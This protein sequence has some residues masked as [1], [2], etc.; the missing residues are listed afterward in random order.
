MTKI[1]WAIVAI[2]AVL[3]LVLLVIGLT[4]RTHPDGGKEM[5]LIFGVIAPGLL[6]GLAVLAFTLSRSTFIRAAALAVAAAPLLLVG[7]SHLRNAW[8]DYQI[9]HHSP[10]T[11]PGRAVPP[12]GKSAP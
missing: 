9:R 11:D 12:Q 5:G 4:S 7:G 2:D 3:F 1:F 10:I 6:V 8:I